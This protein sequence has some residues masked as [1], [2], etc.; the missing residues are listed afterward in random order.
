MTAER[1]E[2][3]ADVEFGNCSMIL[4]ANTGCVVINMLTVNNS[5][6]I[7]L[8]LVKHKSVGTQSIFRET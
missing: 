6:R 2:K 8:T 1:T 3:S 5:R 7:P 4:K